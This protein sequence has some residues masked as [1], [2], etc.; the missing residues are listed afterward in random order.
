MEGNEVFPEVKT[1]GENENEWGL[2]WRV[3]YTTLLH[4]ITNFVLWHI[5]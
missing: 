3:L 2:L 5:L 4:D 1:R